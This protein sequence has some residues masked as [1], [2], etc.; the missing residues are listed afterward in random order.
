MSPNV[1]LLLIYLFNNN[2]GLRGTIIW[3][4]SIELDFLNLELT[5]ISLALYKEIVSERAGDSGACAS[6]DEVCMSMGLC[7][8]GFFN[9]STIDL[10]GWIILGWEE[11][12]YPLYWSTFSR[13]PGQDSLE[14]STNSLSSDNQMLCLVTIF[15]SQ[16]YPGIEFT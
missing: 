7:A 4:V 1:Y 10:G 5:F 3:M 13:T 15:F 9:L 8:S 12:D 14:A 6:G 2:M 11:R 16:L